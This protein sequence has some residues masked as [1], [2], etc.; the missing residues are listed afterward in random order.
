MLLY[1]LLHVTGHIGMGA[2]ELARFRRLDSPASGN[3]EYGAHPAIEA[4]TGPLGQ[5]LANAVG[6]A[7]AER[8]LAS[9]FG[10]SLVDHRTWVIASDGDLMQGVAHE[11]VDLAGHLRLDRLTVLWDDNSS[12]LDGETALSHSADTLKRFAAQG[13]ATKRV[14]GH[15]PAQLAGALA[16]ALRSRKPTLIACRTVPGDCAPHERT[17]AADVGRAMAVGRVAGGGGAAGVAEAVDQASDARRVRAGDGG[18]AAGCV[19]RAHRR[20]AVG[21]RRGAG[22]ALGPRCRA[23]AR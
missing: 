8:M 21:D 17:V 10:R 3:P 23:A 16:L 9:R 4:T 19:A 5:G 12:S 13:W 6:M 14:E 11:A 1:A 22:A 7:L 15:D 18:Q 2:G 20:A